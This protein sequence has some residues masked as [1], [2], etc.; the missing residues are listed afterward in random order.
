MKVPAE[1]LKYMYII[2]GLDA[3]KNC[4]QGFANKDLVLLQAYCPT[5]EGPS[6]TPRCS[7]SSGPRA[8]KLFPCSTQLST[9]F[10]LLINVKMP[11]I[12]AILTFISMINTTSERLKARIFFICLYFSF[13]EQLKLHAQLSWAWKK[14]LTLGPDLNYYKPLPCLVSVFI[15]YL[16][17]NTPDTTHFPTWKYKILYHATNMIFFCITILHVLP[18]LSHKTQYLTANS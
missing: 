3:R 8:L 16:R 15:I 1:Q 11:T 13:Y 7:Y 14:F 10:I 12:V 17:W 4:L 9:K 6:E 5:D 18:I 2:M